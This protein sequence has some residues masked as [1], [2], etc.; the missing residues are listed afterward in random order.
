MAAKIKWLPFVLLLATPISAQTIKLDAGVGN[1]FGS[2]AGGAGMTLYLPRSEMSWSAGYQSGRFL[3]G[4]NDKFQLHGFSTEV[5]SQ[6]TSVGIDGGSVNMNLVGVSVRKITPSFE[7]T[8]F[9]GS[10]GLGFAPGYLLAALPQHAGGGLFITKHL[11]KN[12]MFSSIAAVDASKLTA[13]LGVK[14][15]YK[16]KIKLSGSGGL[17]ENRKFYQGNITWSPIQSLGVFVGHNYFSALN[18]MAQ[19]NSAGIT[20]NLGRYSAQASVNETLFQSLV[21]TGENISAGVRLGPVQL[22]EGWYKSAGQQI[23]S[24][25]ATEQLPKHIFVAETVNTANG[26]NSIGIGG[27]VNWNK[28][29]ISISR[30]L[31]FLVTGYQQTTSISVSVR[32]GS[33]VLS[34]QNVT[35]PFGHAH[36]LISSEAYKQTGIAITAGNHETYRSDKLKFAISGR[37]IN[38]TGGPVAGCIIDVGKETAVSAK[39]GTWSVRFK[40]S[41]PQTIS[42]DVNAFLQGEWRVLSAPA[43]VVTPKLESQADYI[44]I[45]VHK[46]P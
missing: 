26:R 8:A 31:Q 12:L 4:G 16:R 15:D 7:V 32:L 13:A 27:G 17:L 10:V 11:R 28:I 18:E 1:L 33:L 22:R 34:G 20:F 35:D 21:T 40:K 23:W 6:M 3:F 42:V 24:H 19:G 9:V 45:V 2:E 43:A 39:D 30:S 38:E 36:Y 41:S 25:F 46:Q 5:G 37:C 44:V 14:Y 29:Q